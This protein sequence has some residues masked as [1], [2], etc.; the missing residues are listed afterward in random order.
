MKLK[1]H[2]FKLHLSRIYILITLFIHLFYN[3]TYYPPELQLPPFSNIVY[4]G[5]HHRMQRKSNTVNLP[6]LLLL[7]VIL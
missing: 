1:K 7:E 5:I 2:A 6:L 3:F 4:R